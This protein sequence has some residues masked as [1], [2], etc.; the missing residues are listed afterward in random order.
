MDKQSKLKAGLSFGVFMAV[1]IIVKDLLFAD[2]LTTKNIVKIIITGILTGGLSGL[3]FGWI[4]GWFASSKFVKRTTAIE[5][6]PGENIL[7]ETGANHFKG[8]EAVGGR[9]YLTE[10]RLIF[11]SHKLNIQNHQLSIPLSEI[12]TVDRYKSMGIA[13]NGIKITTGSRTEKFVVEKPK[14]WFEKLT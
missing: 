9:L 10:K 14:Q 5:P 11:Q 13:N 8:S 12:Q 3:F 7:F 4:T 2:I 1:F 6:E